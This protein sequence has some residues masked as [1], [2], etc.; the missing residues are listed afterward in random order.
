MAL[1]LQAVTEERQDRWKVAMT[2]VICQERRCGITHGS[3]SWLRSR[4]SLVLALGSRVWVRGSSPLLG[5]SCEGE[6]Q[7]QFLCSG[8]HGNPSLPTTWQQ[9]RSGFDSVH[10][11][12][13]HKPAGCTGKSKQHSPARW[14]TTGNSLGSGGRQYFPVRACKQNM[15]L[16]ELNEKD[17]KILA[18]LWI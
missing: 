18:W 6:G 16:A 11:A 7:P 14:C 3:G 12:P 5:S 1:S 15:V 8:E 10:Q 13:W 9:R 4:Q 2:G 17:A